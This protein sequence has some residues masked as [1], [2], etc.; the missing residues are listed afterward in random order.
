MAAWKFVGG[1]IFAA[2][3]PDEQN[4]AKFSCRFE[5]TEKIVDIVK[6]T[7][8]IVVKISNG[9]SNPEVLLSRESISE[10]T[11]VDVLTKYGISVSNQKPV[12]RL[13]KEILTDTE[14][15]APKTLV[16]NT[17]G[18]VTI[19]NKE[20]YL[21]DKLYCNSQ[22]ILDGATCSSSEMKPKGTLKQYRRFLIKEA[23]QSP[24]LTLAFSLGVTAPVAH[25][26]KKH[27]VFSE[28]LL[29]CACGQS[30]V[31]K[32]TTLRA[33]LSIFGNSEYLLSNLNATGNALETQVSSL[34]GYPFV[35]DEATRS[36]LD[37]DELIYSLSS[38]KGKRRCNG[39][40]TLKDLVTFSG[41]AFFS[42][43]QPI[44]DKCAEQGG[45]EAR[46]IEF[47]M[48]WFDGN[49]SKAE[50]FL[51][52]F[53]NHYGVA[54]D[55]LA[56]LFLDI[57]IQKKIVKHFL[58]AQRKLAEKVCI[59]NGIDKRIVQRLA[60]IAVSCW[61]L[62]KAI[63]V[64]MHIDG[65]VHLLFEVFEDKQ[66]RICRTDAE[67]LL[68]QLFVEDYISNKS[69]YCDDPMIEK[70]TRHQRYILQPKQGSMR[71][72]VSKF[73]GRDCLWL[74]VSVFNEI[75]SRQ[76]TYGA[77]TAKRILH[78]K[79]HLQKFEKSYYRWFNFGPTSANAYCIFLP[80]TLQTHEE[81]IELPQEDCLDIV[82]PEKLIAGFVGL[83]V[84]EH[85]MILNSALAERLR[86][87]K[88]KELY[89]HTWGAR[90]FLVLST[91]KSDSA[92]RLN[93]Q[94]AD[95]SFVT[96]DDRLS[97]ILRT[98]N[99]SI[100]GRERILF[101]DIELQSQDSCAIIHTSNP[102]GQYTDQIKDTDP[103]DIPN[104]FGSQSPL[105]IKNKQ[106]KN[107]LENNNL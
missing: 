78:E 46:V 53:N 44:L 57:G 67:S 10:E 38:G 21:A 82:P 23:T 30:S 86:V 100:K 22:S 60:I 50:R 99:I 33:M 92:I 64:D 43:E 16:F 25:I 35:A 14:E 49:S 76:S 84:Q 55:P 13:V 75:L 98:I 77:S 79:G 17:L 52:F 11:I 102:F 15:I 18:F 61:L 85:A 9:Y 12:R 28:T 37:F 74:P 34:S 90:D 26:L 4:F 31:G 107:L 88:E 69:S 63:K 106:R 87:K 48:D 72:M 91:K 62:Q 65:L 89:L 97:E 73:Q 3:D 71:G 54:I 27:G 41:A 96:T 6:K 39:D 105:K 2:F 94:K 7:E 45:E 66:S 103:Y 70:G 8:K 81:P 104:V 58:K 56:H 68:L 1:D 5:T 32:T 47:E 51:N 20:Y 40:G 42:S 83:T 101:T 93:F 36:K 80:A 24:K 29:W 19:D 95:S 59:K